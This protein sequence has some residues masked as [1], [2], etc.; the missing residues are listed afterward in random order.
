M[1]P[2]Y[3]NTQSTNGNKGLNRK[4]KNPRHIANI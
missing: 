1:K 2:T 4:N 3:F